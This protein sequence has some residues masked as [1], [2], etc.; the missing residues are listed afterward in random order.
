MLAQSGRWRRESEGDGDRRLACAA[1]GAAGLQ[2][3]VRP[4]GF[5]PPTN[6]FG[7]HYSIRLSYERVVQSPRHRQQPE[8]GPAFYPLSKDKSPPP[9]RARSARAQRSASSTARPANSAA[10]TQ[11]LCRKAL[12]HGPRSRVRHSQNS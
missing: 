9:W 3:M 1:C 5:E 7:S 8:S 4:E 10:P 6:G 12:K 11:L 2:E